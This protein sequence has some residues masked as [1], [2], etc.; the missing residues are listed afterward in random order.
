ML[1]AARKIRMD[2]ARQERVLGD[3][4]P[5]GVVVERQKEKPDHAGNNA[6]EREDVRQPNEKEGGVIPQIAD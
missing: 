4:G 5:A 6:Q 2:L 3:V 1:L